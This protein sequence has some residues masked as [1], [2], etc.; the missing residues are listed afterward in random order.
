MIISIN[1]KITVLMPVYNC[2]PFIKEAIDSIL[3]QTFSNFEFIIIDDASTDSTVSIIKTYNDP[4][5][6]LII[7]PDNLGLTNSLNYGLSI[8]KGEYI[9]RM[10]GD[11]ISLPE[12]FAKQVVFL[13]KNPETVL[14]GAY[15]KI[16]GKDKIITVPEYHEDIKLAMLK[17][18]CIGHPTVMMRKSCLDKFSLRYDEKK[19][20]AEDY[21]L[22]TRF[23]NVG[24]LY[25]LQEVLLNYRVHNS[26]VSH[27][28]NEQ[29][30]NTALEI[31]VNLLMNLN[32]KRDDE[33]QNFLKK[34]IS[35]KE[36]VSFAEINQFEN[37]KSKLL[38]ANQTFFFEKTGFEKYLLE[39]GSNLFKSY[40]LKR[41]KYSP[42]VYLQYLRI[43]KK[44]PIKLKLLDEVKLF[45][46]SMILYSKK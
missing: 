25:N 23:L 41:K 6:K 26:Q 38:L 8:A 24:K 34:I 28:R 2:E 30:I 14:I 11:D 27:K 18:C 20:P 33:T 32:F 5:I 31:K 19:E 17:D 42:V 46:K 35:G 45:V 7:K 43:R 44:A 15:F 12:R 21:D 37:L 3:N 4:R 22:W 9:A 13:D 29:Q 40:F 16:I 36:S 10:D 39:I 1:P